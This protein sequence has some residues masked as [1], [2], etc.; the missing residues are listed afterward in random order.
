MNQPDHI[1]LYKPMRNCVLLEPIV[2]HNTFVKGELKLVNPIW[3]KTA[4]E[5]QPVIH[6]VIETPK[7]LTYGTTKELVV[8]H[9]HERHVDPHI[10]NASREERQWRDIPKP[11]S[12]PWKPPEK[13]PIKS[14]DIVWTGYLTIVT[15]EQENRVI[16]VDGKKYYLVPF[17]RIYLKHTN[18]GIQMLNGW[19]LVE[20][21]KTDDT[22]DRLKKL[23]IIMP[24]VTEKPEKYGTVR[25]IAPPV[26]EYL[27]NE[28][29]PD[30]DDISVG[31]V[32]RLKFD[33]NPKILGTKDNAYFNSE[34]PL[35]VT[36]RP[37]ILGI[38]RNK[39]F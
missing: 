28:Y 19:V 24:D 13:M 25:H 39:I 21:I 27:M 3:D 6:R 22:R 37:Y 30:T 11:N 31:D 4:M 26:E 29:P 20:P 18:R 7:V 1:G 9:R 17:D 5:N 36:R 15:A 33:A 10:N 14:G 38:M 23:N 16:T 32:V 34:E 12:M 8:V 2:H 35:I